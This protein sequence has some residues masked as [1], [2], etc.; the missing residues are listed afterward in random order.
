MDNAPAAWLLSRVRTSWRI[1]AHA[2]TARLLRLG[3]VAILV[4][5]ST[6]P[7]AASAADGARARA[8]QLLQQA[9]RDDAD[10]ELARAADGYEEALRLDPSM[11]KAMRAQQRAANIRE[12]SE[13]GFQPLAALERVRRDPKLASD[14]KAIDELVRLAEGF[15]PGLVRVEAW[16]LAA[17]AYANRLERPSDSVGLWQRIIVDPHADR[18]TAGAAAR[19]LATYHLTREDFASAE[20][21]IALAGSK[22]DATIARDVHRAVR[23]H[24]L[25]RFSIATLAIALA[26]ATLTIGRSVRAGKLAAI[27]GRARASSR[28]VIVYAAYVAIGGAVLATGYEEGTSRPFLLFGAV[29]VPILL[30]ARAWGAAGSTSTRARAVRAAVCATSAL[31]AAFLVL[32]RVDVAYLEGMGL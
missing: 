31:A 23:R 26:A 15:P 6:F 10:L 13:G 1:L 3:L 5:L 19:S 32:E 27:L 8:L 16:V 30:I 4:T 14:P 18:V 2:A 25:H 22:V 11:A 28:L 17:E 20:A 29:L 9:E 7:I 12:R 24:H 21:T